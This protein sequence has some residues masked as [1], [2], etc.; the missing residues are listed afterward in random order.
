MKI[1]YTYS[2]LFILNVVPNFLQ[3]QTIVGIW[4][5]KDN[6]RTYQITED[7][8]RI[9]TAVI[10]QSYRKNDK[11]GDTILSNVSLDGLKDDYVGTIHSTIHLDKRFARIK[12]DKDRKVLLI[13]IPRFVFFPVSIQWHR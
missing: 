9:F 5:S 8:N 2:I 11:R 1:C 3:S 4:K 12:V 10:H 6:S 13:K 7:S